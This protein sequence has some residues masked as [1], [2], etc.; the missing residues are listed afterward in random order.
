MV[1]GSS[2]IW[3]I[4][5]KRKNNDFKLFFPTLILVSFFLFPTEPR[6]FDYIPFDPYVNLT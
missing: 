2:S 1:T 5:G 4:E 6:I 3:G